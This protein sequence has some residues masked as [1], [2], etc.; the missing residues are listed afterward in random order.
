MDSSAGSVV[1]G[2]NHKQTFSIMHIDVSHAHVHA[3]AQESCAGTS[4]S[5]GQSGRRTW[6][7]IGKTSSNVGVS[8]GA[9]LEESVST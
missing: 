3:K 4:A 5:G 6:S 2:A 1:G 8:V 9:Q 7:V